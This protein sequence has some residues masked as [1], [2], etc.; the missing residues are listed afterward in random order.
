MQP[1]PHSEYVLTFN[2]KRADL[3]LLYADGID[4]DGLRGIPG[5]LSTYNFETISLFHIRVDP[6]Y[7]AGEVKAAIEKFLTPD[8]SAFDNTIDALDMDDL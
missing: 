1:K 4:I 6:R 2:P 8:T 5:V 3:L 7:H